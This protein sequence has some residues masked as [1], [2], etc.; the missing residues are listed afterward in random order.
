VAAIVKKEMFASQPKV[1]SEKVAMIFQS[2]QG[3]LF[4]FLLDKQ[5]ACD[6]L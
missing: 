2:T 5:F 6:I 3:V 4:L 1:N